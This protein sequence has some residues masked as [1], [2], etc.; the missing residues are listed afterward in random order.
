MEAVLKCITQRLHVLLVVLGYRNVGLRTV[1]SS[2]DAAGTITRKREPGHAAVDDTLS[3]QTGDVGDTGEGS[4]ILA[5]WR[6]GRQRKHA[7]AT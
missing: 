3:R 2:R 5:D 6:E 7:S 1:H 4:T